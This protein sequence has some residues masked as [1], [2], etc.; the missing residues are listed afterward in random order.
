[1][2]TYIVRRLGSA[3]VVMLGVAVMTFVLLHLV[4]SSP[5]NAVLGATATKEQ[6]A[7]FNHE[8]GY[9]DP[10]VIQ[11]ITYVGNLFRGDLGFSYTLNQG[12]GNLLLQN[13]GRSAY[14]SIAALV[15]AVVVSIPVGIYQATH[16]NKISDHALTLV[17]LIL[18]AM[19]AF[20]F[21]L[22]L[23]SIFG[24]TLHWLPFEGSQSTSTWGAILDVRHM[25][26]PI[27]SLAAVQVATFSKYVR[28]SALDNLGMDYMR[29]ARA[30]GL[31]E[32]RIRYV[33]LA[34]NSCLPVIAMVGLSIPSVLAGNVL[35]ETLFNYPGLG[36][37]FY[38][39]LQM[40]DYPILL[41][42][43]I[44]GAGLVVVGSLVADLV[45]VAVDPR[46]RL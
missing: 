45:S 25:I 12:V 41:G 17:T 5:A 46:I 37:L 32:R 34:R 19:P 4:S 29:L 11:F 21:G 23:V 28:S 8:H 40:A 9:D 22:I 31:A 3:L 35:I 7:A 39:A 44:L 26:M 13:V 33:H 42:I 27:V 2:I 16:R 24:M 20:F 38:N 36:L 1:M 30:K 15:L 18:L 10:I 43:T 14:L 6:I